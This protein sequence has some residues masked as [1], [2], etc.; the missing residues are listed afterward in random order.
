MNKLIEHLYQDLGDCIG[1]ILE[2]PEATP[3]IKQQLNLLVCDFN[4]QAG[5]IKNVS[6]ARAREILPAAMNLLTYGL[7]EDEE[8]ETD[9]ESAE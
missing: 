7:P 4:N 1:S 5:S 9:G 8:A 3:E 2:H 6:A